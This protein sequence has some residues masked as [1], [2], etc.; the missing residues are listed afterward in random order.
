MLFYTVINCK[1]L[2]SRWGYTSLSM[3]F[4]WKFAGKVAVMVRKPK[5]RADARNNPNLIDS[6]WSALGPFE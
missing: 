3:C 6:V 2:R 5:G 1:S 4:N